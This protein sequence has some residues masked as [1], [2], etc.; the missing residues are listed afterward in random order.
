I[1]MMP[2]IRDKMQLITKCGIKMVSPNRPG[3]QIKHYDTSKE[4]IRFSVES[5]LRNLRTDF[6]DLLL[7]HRPDSL[8]D[9]AEIAMIFT[10]LKEE[11]KVLHF[12]VSNFSASQL[13]LINTFFPLSSIQVEASVMALSAFRNGTLDQCMVNNLIPM[14][15]SPLG[16]GKLFSSEDERSE[17]ILAVTS[18]LAEKYTCT[19]DQVLLAWLLK[20]PSGIKPVLGTARAERVK[21]AMEAT[22]INMTREEWYLLWRAST[23]EEVA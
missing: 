7:L 14:A 10:K 2:S 9:P 12:G 19:V 5:S 15:W 18:I 11:G 6:I 4:H 13:S 3:H 1:N 21:A 22:Q 20:H 17:R 8:M 23:G 16:G